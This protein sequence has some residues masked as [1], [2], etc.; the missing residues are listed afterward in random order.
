MEKEVG[1]EKG[2]GKQRAVGRAAKP[3]LGSKLGG[4]HGG[5]SGFCRHGACHPLP[6][7]CHLQKQRHRSQG[8]EEQGVG[9]Q[10]AKAQGSR[11]CP[12]RYRAGD[13]GWPRPRTRVKRRKMGERTTGTGKQRQKD[14]WEREGGKSAGKW[15]VWG[16]EQRE[17]RKFPDRRT[18]DPSARISPQDAA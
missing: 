17:T 9:T 6:W 16:A 3:L 13:G 12:L 10:R 8:S 2:E 4:N 7:P 1:E 18:G 14:E 5:R 15:L 11:T